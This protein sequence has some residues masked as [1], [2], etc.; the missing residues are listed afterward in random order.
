MSYQDRA[1]QWVK[2]GELAKDTKIR[3]LP[4]AQ[5]QPFKHFFIGDTRSHVP[6]AQCQGRMHRSGSSPVV[7]TI[8]GRQMGKTVMRTS[9]D[10][11]IMRSLLAKYVVHDEMDF[12]PSWWPVALPCQE[13]P[14]AYDKAVRVK[15]IPTNRMHLSAMQL[16]EGVMYRKERKGKPRGVRKWSWQERVMGI[17]R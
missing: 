2:L 10:L 6:L 3:I 4:S 5:L 16:L 7:Y 8:A 12:L 1:L 17:A 11:H 9:I 15:P 13:D 14:R